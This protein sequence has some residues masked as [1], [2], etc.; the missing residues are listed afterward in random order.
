LAEHPEINHPGRLTGAM[1]KELGDSAN[2][3][4]LND[5]CQSVLG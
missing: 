2:G 1:K 3:K 4:M 5:V